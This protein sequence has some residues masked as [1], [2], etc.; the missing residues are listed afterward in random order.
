MTNALFAIAAAAFVY[1][2]FVGWRLGFHQRLPLAFSPISLPE[3]LDRAARK[4]GNGPLFTCDSPVPWSVAALR[5]IYEDDAKW[6]AVRIRDTASHVAGAFRQVGV[7]RGDRVAIIKRNH[8]DTHLLIA[9]AVRSGAIACPINGAFAAVHVGP[10]LANIGAR[11]LVTD[12]QTLA[13]LIR[14]GAA[15][16]SV[17]TVILAEKEKDADPRDRALIEE[18]LAVRWIEPLLQMSVPVTEPEPRGREDPVYLTHSSGT[19]GFSKAV[20]LRNGAQS[21]AVRGWLCYV[22]LSRRDRG[23]LAV[24][25]NH[26]AVILSFNALLLLGLRTHW[27]SSY[28]M[29][30]FDAGRVLAELAEGRFTGFFGFPICYTQMKEADLERH[31]LSAMRFWASTAD[32]AH[33]AIERRFVAVGGAFRSLG[34]PLSGSVYLDAQGS[35]EV[36]TPSVVRYVTPWTR[37]FERRVGR[38]FSSPFGPKVRITRNGASVPR[39]EV[40]RLEVKGR[41]VFNAYWNNH[42]LTCEAFQ[43]EWFFTGDVA[44]ISPDGHI[45]QL[46]REVDVIQSKNGPIYSLP[47]EER[48]HYHPAV[49]DICVFGARVD[50]HQ[51]PAAMIAL[52]NGCL[53]EETKLL[54]E[55]NAMLEPNEKLDRIEVV[56]W[57]E[58]PIGV[59]GKTLKRVLRER[60]ES[61]PALERN[62]PIG[63]IE[64]QK[65]L[66]S[67]VVR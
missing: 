66:Q 52:R 39:G 4:H 51:A 31:D 17:E 21:H 38:P 36:G 1:L 42:S 58:F 10:Y 49:F 24:P 11:M 62:R 67:R 29:K 45:V 7:R 44:R 28:G 61:K 22:H 9:G 5:E 33:A 55:L 37:R 14:E 6:G 16:A 32:A 57:W 50:G 27:S 2:L 64:P 34:I 59:T 56:N 47:I 25:N 20:I 3:I 26:Q 46:D 54:G 15:L 40:G 13:R 30:D 63:F 8:F 43:D 18:A 35:S 41:T 23:Y 60:T 19:T 48:L 65:A 12:S 53:V